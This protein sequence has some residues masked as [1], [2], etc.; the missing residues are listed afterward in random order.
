MNF[1]DQLSAQEKMRIIQEIVPGK[2]ITLAHIIANQMCIRDRS[3]SE[4]R[5]MVLESNVARMRPLSSMMGASPIRSQRGL[6]SGTRMMYG[7]EAWRT[8]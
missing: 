3:K 1:L 8:T 7:V 2:Q 5:A 4:R 6:P